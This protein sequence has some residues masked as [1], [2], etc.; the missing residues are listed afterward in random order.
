MFVEHINLTNTRLLIETSANRP[1]V[2]H[3]EYP[4]T[5]TKN[6]KDPGITGS[7]NLGNGA[8]LCGVKPGSN[9]CNGSLSN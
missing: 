3:L 7:I 8:Q 2:L 1:V 5:S 6:P 9:T 4:G